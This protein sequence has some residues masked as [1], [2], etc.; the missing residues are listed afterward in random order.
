MGRALAA[1]KRCRLCQGRTQ[2]VF[3]VGNPAARVVFMGEGP[4]A[5]EDRLG[6][7]FVGKAGKLLNAMLP[8][9]GLKRAD[10]YI[11]NVVKCRPPGNRDP[12]PDEAAACMPF[13]KRQIE[14]IDPLVIVCLGRIAARYLLGTTAPISSYRGRWTKWM[15]R[16]VLPTYHPAYL[17]RNPAAKRESWSDFKK[18]RERLKQEEGRG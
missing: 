3:G 13:L 7:P 17:L 2:V 9:I 1:C 8:S 5:D 11:A 12:E 18:L 16:D 10:V 14:L 4:G 15:G 6:E